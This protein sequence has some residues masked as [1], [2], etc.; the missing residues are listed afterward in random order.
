MEIPHG[1]GLQSSSEDEYEESSSEEEDI[2]IDDNNGPVN[3]NPPI[4]Y[5]Y[6]DDFIG[7]NPFTLYTR[8]DVFALKAGGRSSSSAVIVQVF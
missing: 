3:N 7:D 5:G 4:D 1:I 8:R 2:N 6:D